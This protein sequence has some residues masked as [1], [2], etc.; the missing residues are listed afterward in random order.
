MSLTEKRICVGVILGAHGVRGE[1]RIKTF[2][3]RPEAVAALGAVENEDASRRFQLKVTR[4]IKEGVAAVVKG[5]TD[6]DTAEALKGSMLYVPRSALP[7]LEADADEFYLV[8]LI[9]LAVR[10]VEGPVEEEGRVLA[11]H[12]FGAGDLLE[13]A[14]GSEGAKHRT[15]LLPFERETVPE[16]NV[17]AG[18]I[19]AIPP[20]E[21]E[22]DKE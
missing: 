2:T 8:D 9:G 12:N 4:T 7:P 18:Y 1:V 10:W 13:V 14:I 15:L 11:V 21:V 19:T 6:R 3:A 17:A 5:V 22:E 20:I 16:V